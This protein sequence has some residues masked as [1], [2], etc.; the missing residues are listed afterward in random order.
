MTSY[1]DYLDGE[2]LSP[3]LFKAQVALNIFTPFNGLYNILDDELEFIS[4]PYSLLDTYILS[5][6]LN[7]G[8]IVE[9]FD[10]SVLLEIIEHENRET[11]N[12]KY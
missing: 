4:G 2:Y 3:E 5:N 12:E 9:W 11:T 1:Y 7:P 10:E 8:T 6:Y